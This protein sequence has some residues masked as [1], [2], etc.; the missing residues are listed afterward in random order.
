MADLQEAILVANAL[1]MA[2]TRR[3]PQAGYSITR[4]AGAPI[5]AKSIS[6]FCS[7]MT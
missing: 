6:H 4:I 7:S 5:R 2:L 1:D 3:R